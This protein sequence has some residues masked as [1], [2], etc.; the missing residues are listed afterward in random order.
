MHEQISNVVDAVK[1]GSIVLIHP[2]Y[3]GHDTI[4]AIRNIV[5]LLKDEGYD[6]VTA[7]ELLALR[8]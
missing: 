7:S 1:P 2:W 4:E 8:K 5:E 3:G 6:F